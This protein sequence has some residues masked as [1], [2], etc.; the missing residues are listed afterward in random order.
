[1]SIFH[2]N[3]RTATDLIPDEE[4]VELIN[5]AAAEADAVRAARAIMAAGVYGG[6][7]QLGE[8][9]E[10]HDGVGDFLSA[11]HFADVLRIRCGANEVVASF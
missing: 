3:L 7:L 2:L 4:G 1:M 9:I 11:V 6:D 10:I 8:S 5:L